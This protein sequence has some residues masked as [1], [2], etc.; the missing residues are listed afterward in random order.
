MY[1]HQ[2]EA[3]ERAID[4]GSG[5]EKPAIVV[6]AGTGSGK[7][8]AFL[9]PILNELFARDRGDGAGTQC[10]ILYPMNAL[11]NDQV[12]RLYKWLEGQD[13]IRLFNFTSE[14]PEDIKAANRAGIPK[15]DSCRVRTRQE[16]RESPVPD[17][18]IT[19][20]S[21]LEYML[22]RPQDSVFFG[23][24]LRAVVLD[25]AHLYTGTLAAEITLLLR[26]LFLRCGVE[27]E[28]V[29]QMAT[30]ATLGTGDADELRDFAATIFSKKAQLVHI[31]E[32]ESTRVKLDE[33]QS[34]EEKPS[35]ASVAGKTWIDRPLVE[36]NDKGEAYLRDDPEFC[37]RLADI[38]KIWVSPRRIKSI[39]R[40]ETRPAVWLWEALSAS[41][42]VHR[43]EEFLWERGRMP[44]NELAERLWGSHDADAKRATG[45]LL[46]LTSS[47][48]REVDDYPLVPHRIHLM[49]RANDGLS[50]CLD[51]QCI[52]PQDLKLKGLGT[53]HTGFS[54]QCPECGGVVLP[55][56]HCTNCGEWVLAGEQTG[57]ILRPVAQIPLQT[58]TFFTRHAK[59]DSDLRHFVVNS[60]NGSCSGAGTSGVELYEIER[61]LGCGSRSFMPFSS[62]SNLFLS[63]LAETVL[64]ELPPYPSDSRHWLPAR[65]RRLLAFSDSRQEA[66]RLGPN[67]TRQHDTQV[68]RAAIVGCMKETPVGDEQTINTIREMIQS[69][70]VAL[71][72]PGLTPGQRQVLQT[73]RDSLRG[74]LT[75]MKSGGSMKEWAKMLGRQKRMEEILDQDLSKKQK[76]I[77]QDT[78]GD[79]KWSQR[80]W[81]KNTREVRK[82]AELFLAREFARL[83]R[84]DTSLE[85]LG[86]AEVT[87]PGLEE[88]PAPG[89]LLGL[90][91]DKQ[92]R[93]KIENIWR[94]FLVALCDSMRMEGI[95]TIADKTNRERLDIRFIDRWCVRRGS[96][97]SYLSNFIGQT[98]EQ[99]RRQFAAAVLYACGMEAR[100]AGEF[101]VKMLETA[102]DNLL[103]RAADN[104]QQSQEDQFA[105]L[106]KSL[107]QTQDGPPKEA[108]QLVFDYLGL[109]RPSALFQCTKTGHVWP[110]SVMGCA[111]EIGCEG[112]LQPIGEDELVQE[113]KV[114][115]YRR[116]YNRASV[117]QIGLW[118]EE[119]SAQ[120]APAEN[121]RLQDLF[122][123]GIRNVLSATTT[124]E[125]GVDIGG[126]NAVLMSNVPPG[127]SNYLQRAGRA[128]RRADG[129]SVVITYVRPQ[130]YD[131]E[132]FHRFGDYLGRPLRKPLVFL[133][134]DRV[135]RRHAFSFL[136]GTFFRDIYPS[137]LRTG[138]MNAFG[139]MGRFCGAI[140]PSYWERKED[141]PR[142]SRVAGMDVGDATSIPWIT[143]STKIN[144]LDQ[145]FR[146]F[147][148][149][150]R[151]RE[152]HETKDQIEWLLQNTRIAAE[153]ECWA[154]FIEATDA[155]FKEAV[156]AWEDEYQNLL[157]AWKK[158]KDR[159]Q[160]NAIRYQLRTLHELT[161]IEVLADQQFLPHYGFPIGL[162]QLQVIV[163][164]ETRAGRIRLEDQ[165]RLERNN[166]LALRE[167]VP[168][169]QLLVGGKLVVSRGLL[170]HWTGE[171]LNGDWGLRGLCCSCENGH[172]YYST[173][174]QLENCP[175]CDAEQAQTSD[176]LLFPKHGFSS[177]AWDPP[178]WS[179][180]IERIGK[181]ET[182]TITFTGHGQQEEIEQQDFAGVKGLVARYREKGEILVY[183][184]GDKDKGFALCLR[185]G[186]A[187]SEREYGKAIMD[188]PSSFE[189]HAPLNSPSP[190]RKCWD[191]GKA[192][193]LRNQILAAREI[194]DVLLID[195]SSCLGEF[196]LVRDIITTLG[197]VL[198]SAGARMLELDNREL[199]VLV[200]P[201]GT[202]GKGWGA[203]IY[204]SVAG[205]AGHVRE[206]LAQ[207]RN[208]LKEA[209]RILW[210]S[211]DHH[212]RC[213]TACLDCLMSFSAQY[214]VGQVSF[215]RRRA[216]E[217][218]KALLEGR[219]MPIWDGGGKKENASNDSGGKSGESLGEKGTLSREERMRE[220][221]AR[222]GQRTR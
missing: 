150:L 174:K 100:A 60:Q 43:L 42:L 7:T 40:G 102:F 128:G 49:A 86:L 36:I 204:D 68:L 209:R 3:L 112:T 179:S 203:V 89:S 120:L 185:C 38:L 155:A 37:A 177:A 217:V 70:E 2:H 47:A 5:G 167:Y 55:L 138:A 164:D 97:Q 196:D 31:I 176:Q 15:W 161:V 116:E 104:G 182:A 166:L 144:R 115:R 10:I 25:E 162:H 81:E 201:V 170:K 160:A 122:K 93:Q 198:Q 82:K 90:L 135:V 193:V 124:L 62:Q 219:E 126:L 211:D 17:I 168:G 117:F 113:S 134:R 56:Y 147:L 92:V 187:D 23:P 180:D 13:R 71:A 215:K 178:R 77:V 207:G 153:V 186:Y 29:L 20:Y 1:K 129:S 72:N 61:C 106:Q 118:A 52:G 12:D 105:W 67:L 73:N 181:I 156:K 9:L 171:M 96:S 91:P 51:S 109:R 101:A 39:D 78:D 69:S 99:R 18:V 154:G 94:D 28:Q 184:R 66:A 157:K 133:D 206:L 8:E 11:V 119:H 44:L 46:Q 208:W 87:Y 222:L 218:L 33:P 30:S 34:P 221:K 98:A 191:D 4:S 197:H 114:G 50:S 14:T 127:K 79:R 110:R 165:F 84:R 146:N 6:T 152:D 64:A 131:R 130:P 137:D 32:G 200:V 41:P 190:Y 85:V 194:T 16:A 75:S 216:Y 59:A 145:C 169:S 195:F 24:A 123:F 199:G 149:W 136:L 189:T 148:Q 143:E 63:I 188:L 83:Y 141:K 220:A 53:V 183:N 22:C 74:Q 205:G 175:I 80:D 139:N 132:V 35:P 27:P 213:E 163:P 26:R 159:T 88:C 202:E 57:G 58:P 151:E 121:R 142:A 65:G 192:P 45:T 19:N 172:F 21:M 210:V 48:R 76:A 111:P 103:S 158:S 125:L 95:V 214:V 140:L 107:R 173:A 54:D 108:L 212:E